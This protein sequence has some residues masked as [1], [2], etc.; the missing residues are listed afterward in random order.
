MGLEAVL[1]EIRERGRKEVER[2][3][4][5]SQ[6]ETTRV[7]SAAQER[8]AKIK[9]AAN[10]EVERHAAFIMNQEISAA[11]LQVKRQLLNTQK[12]LLDQVYQQARRDVAALPESFHREAIT[13]LLSRAKSQIAD[14]IVHANARDRGLLEQILAQK[15]EFKGFSAGD[16]VDIEG[17]VIIES[18]DGTL[19]LDYSYRTFLDRVWESGLKDASDLLFG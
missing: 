8:A 9:Q 12:E 10:E 17:G 18:R 6:E 11:N 7:L 1:E 16:N 13:T 15:S 5:E 19:Q 2:I 3:R 4:R 14:G